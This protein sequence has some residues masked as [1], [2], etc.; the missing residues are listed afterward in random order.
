MSL[1][2]R[3]VY[4]IGAGGARSQQTCLFFSF[5]KRL[6]CLILNKIEI[7]L[8]ILGHEWSLA[9]AKGIFQQP[10]FEAISKLSDPPFHLPYPLI[11]W[12]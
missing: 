10:D 5:E 6:D 11:N 4:L 9:T 12:K 8:V 1:Q 2:T 3:K 7:L